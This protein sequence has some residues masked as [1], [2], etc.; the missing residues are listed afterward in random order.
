M[1]R[2]GGRCLGPRTST[3]GDQIG[4]FLNDVRHETVDVRDDRL[5]S[6]ARFDRQSRSRRSAFL[7]GLHVRNPRLKN[8]AEELLKLEIA[9]E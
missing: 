9:Q 7:S 2:R 6:L 3:I 4:L 8:F 5:P 1:A